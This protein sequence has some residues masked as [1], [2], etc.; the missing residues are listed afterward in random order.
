MR[1][2]IMTENERGVVCLHFWLM[3]RASSQMTPMIREVTVHGSGISNGYRAFCECI[4][5]AK[6]D[7]C[8]ASLIVRTSNSPPDATGGTRS[9]RLLGA[10][11]VLQL[12]GVESVALG[13]AEESVEALWAH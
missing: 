2:G 11:I 12:A 1:A 5:R 4:S 6:E 13:A 3:W 10:R 7:V 9:E 8:E